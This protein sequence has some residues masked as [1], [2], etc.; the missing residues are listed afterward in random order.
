M[1]EAESQAP[2]AIPALFTEPPALQ[3]PLVT[4]TTELQNDT[5]DKCLPFLRGVHTSQKGPFNEHG[6]PALQRND[7]LAF[8][9]DSLED[10]PA[11]FAGMDASRPWMV[12]WALAAL[13]LLGE[14]VDHF[15]DRYV[16]EC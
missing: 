10:Y 1:A 12:Y 14:D 7:H 3:D 4:E 6:V 11:G 8:L 2:S 13:S 16:T 9:Y 15:R 5:L